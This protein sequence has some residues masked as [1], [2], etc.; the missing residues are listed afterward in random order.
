MEDSQT[1]PGRRSELLRMLARALEVSIFVTSPNVPTNRE[2]QAALD[3][4]VS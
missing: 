4:S 1:T 2:R 3:A